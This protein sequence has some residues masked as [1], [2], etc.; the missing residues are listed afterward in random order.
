MTNI[1]NSIGIF[2]SGVGGL[3]VWQEIDYLLPNE[4]IVYY[5]DNANCPYGEKTQDEVIEYSGKVTQFLIDKGCK[6]IVVAC[7]TATSQAIDYLR[8]TFAVPF[9][10]IVP[11]VKPAA[12]N[13]KT[14]VIAILATAGTLK[15]K[16]FNDT[17]KEFSGNTEVILVEAGELVDIVENGLQGTK[18][19]E[20]ILRKHINPL[21]KRQI[22]HLVLGCTHF[23]FLIEDI[24]M[25]TGDSVILDNP[26][27]A[28][29]QRTKFILESENLTVTPDNKKQIEF[30]S[31]GNIETL[32][33]MV[34]NIAG[35]KSR[36]N[37]ETKKQGRLIVLSS[38]PFL[39]M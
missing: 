7:N 37:F 11:A 26:A 20:E 30:F 4:S 16:K 9:V 32:K 34:R 39:S 38:D 33:N 28:I 17:M 27:P 35:I 13:S 5:A 25:I 21:M 1:N 19:S 8:K 31:S 2:D 36:M 15:S 6:I 29:A 10:G 22:D 14:G 24:K 3:S 18:Y 23:P 12:I